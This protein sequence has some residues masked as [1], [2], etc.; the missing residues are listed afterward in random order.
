ML[1]MESLNPPLFEN[2]TIIMVASN[3]PFVNKKMIYLPQ[4]RL[5][6]MDH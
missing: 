6:N 2:V 3:H 4:D 1:T 5:K